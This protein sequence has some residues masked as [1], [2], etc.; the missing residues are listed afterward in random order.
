MKIKAAFNEKC[1]QQVDFFRKGNT[2][3]D[4]MSSIVLSKLK[5]QFSDFSLELFEKVQDIFLEQKQA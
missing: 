5:N 2:L 3:F 4:K 1:V